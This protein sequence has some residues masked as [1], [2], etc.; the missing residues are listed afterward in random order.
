MKWN[1]KKERN[2]ISMLYKD[3]YRAYAN[4]ANI[5]IS[6]AQRRMSMIPEFCKAILETGEE[7][8]IPGFIRLYTEI[9]APRTFRNPKT[10]EAFESG[11]RIRVK[12]EVSK[13]FKQHFLNADFKVCHGDD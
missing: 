13:A 4:Y 6:E 11:E 9:E 1:D 10:G 12:S 7:I 5:S 8:K 3:L 2:G